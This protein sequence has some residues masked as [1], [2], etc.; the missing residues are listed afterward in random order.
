MGMWKRSERTV[1]KHHDAI[2]EGIH[3]ILL[4]E[5]QLEARRLGSMP[6][7]RLV[8]KHE[9]QRTTRRRAGEHVQK[10]REEARRLLRQAR[11]LDKA[12]MLTLPPQERDETI[13]ARY[14]IVAKQEGLKIRFQTIAQRTYRNRKGKDEYEAEVM[15]VWIVEPEADS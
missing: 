8:D 11:E 14:R 4:T 15:A 2:A 13:K 5:W 7:A 9:V 3:A 10:E 6:N 1:P 12:I